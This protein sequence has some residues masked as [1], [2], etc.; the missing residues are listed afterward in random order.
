M[1]GLVVLGIAS[2]V[3]TFGFGLWLL[4][5]GFS[6]KPFCIFV[7]SVIICVGSFLYVG[8]TDAQW[9]IDN[10]PAI[11]HYSQIK[12]ITSKTISLGDTTYSVQ[13]NVIRN[14]YPIDLSLYK[15]GD[16]V[17]FETIAGA[18]SDYLIT[19]QKLNCQ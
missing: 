4:W 1:T 16:L 9:A 18:Y 8:I 7:I 13:A 17:K 3:C 2:A 11:T 6:I 14:K 10:S 12:D 5:E 15:I 19:V